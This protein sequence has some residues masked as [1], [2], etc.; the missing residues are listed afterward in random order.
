MQSALAASHAEDTYLRSFY[1]R[2]SSKRG[3]KKARVATAH[4][5]LIVA[6]FIIPDGVATPISV[7][8]N[9]TADS[10]SARSSI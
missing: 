2:I 5:Q 7:R 10:R 6:F 4:K 8:I 1:W 9:S 3:P